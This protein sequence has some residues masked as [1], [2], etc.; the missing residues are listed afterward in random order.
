MVDLDSAGDSIKVVLNDEITVLF[1]DLSD[2]IKGRMTGRMYNTRE[3]PRLPLHVLGLV[4]SIAGGRR[5]GNIKDELARATAEPIPSAT[6][7][8][9][10]SE[11][12]S[13]LMNGILST[14]S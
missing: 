12:Q 2:G 6:T 4:P 13:R 5:S 8:Q 3:A 9:S 10:S 11:L 14:H 1:D 7:K